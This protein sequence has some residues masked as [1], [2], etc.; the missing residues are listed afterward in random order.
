M[1][2]IFGHFQQWNLPKQ[3]KMHFYLFLIL[4]DTVWYYAIAIPFS[5]VI[6]SACHSI[7]LSLLSIIL[8]PFTMI[9]LSVILSL[10]HSIYNISICNSTYICL[11]QTREAVLVLLK[12]NVSLQVLSIHLGHFFRELNGKY[13]NSNRAKALAP[14]KRLQPN[15]SHQVF[16]VTQH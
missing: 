12:L 11:P 16:R 2:S 15:S 8:P 6:W 13:F 10:Y 1:C 3:V 14:S 9:Y 4:G 7:Y 5:S